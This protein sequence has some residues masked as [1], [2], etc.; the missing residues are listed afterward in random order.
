MKK[1]ILFIV[2]SVLLLCPAC[3]SVIPD[4]LPPLSGGAETPASSPTAE[5]P[6]PQPEFRMEINSL[7]AKFGHD[8]TYVFIN[9][10]D[11]AVNIV[12]IPHLERKTSEGWEDVEFAENIGF[13]GT[14]DCLAAFSRSIEWTLETEYL[15]GGSLAAGIYR[16]SF[17]IVDD[18]Y[19]PSDTISAVFDVL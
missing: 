12:S 7:S 11:S 6:A 16:L 4:Q 13:C 17:D 3:F 8:I 14:P 5:I 19:Y 2:L 15:Y 1:L 10:T 18:D 9:D